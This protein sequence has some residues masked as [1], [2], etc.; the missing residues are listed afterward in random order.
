MIAERIRL[1]TVYCLLLSALSCGPTGPGGLKPITA[2]DA[3]VPCPGGRT[4]W[5][6]EV[7]DR[8]AE[9]RESDKVTALVANSIRRSFP[10]CRWDTAPADAPTITIELNTFSAKYSYSES[11]WDAA[12]AWT[13]SARDASGRSL[14]EFECEA[15][16]SR[17]NYSSSNN[18]KLILN[19]VF[20]AALKRALAGL[21]TIPAL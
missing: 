14:R 19:Q 3:E 8:R 12:A 5:K 6:L 13:V 9:R 21:R 15:T 11:M 1:P 2:P 18:E 4:T 20:E 7:L 17:P 10:A 16:A